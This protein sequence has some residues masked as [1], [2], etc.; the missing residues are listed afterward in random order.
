MDAKRGA[1]RRR[2]RVYRRQ[3]PRAVRVNGGALPAELSAGFGPT[4]QL[5]FDEERTYGGLLSTLDGE[6]SVMAQCLFADPVSD[7]ALLG[8]PDNQSF[9]E[10]A[11]AYDALLDAAVPFRLGA[12]RFVREEHRLPG[13][14]SV[15][16]LP[17]ERKAVAWM[18]TATN[19]NRDQPY[20]R[21]RRPS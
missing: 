1:G 14:K 20:S 13:T 11:E 3:L 15:Y 4:G 12:V 8:S 18:L 19:I 21:S 9:Y 10:E 16:T 5:S 2:A 17:P 6:P 7:V